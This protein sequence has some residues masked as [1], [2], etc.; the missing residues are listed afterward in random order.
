MKQNVFNITIVLAFSGLPGFRRDVEFFHQCSW[1]LRLL[2][3]S[4][5][6]LCP[7]TENQIIFSLNAAR[8]YAAGDVTTSK[9][10]MHCKRC[11]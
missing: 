10:G 2:T 9:G 5:P 4:S 8:P 11:A 6:L 1:S 7:L 3:T